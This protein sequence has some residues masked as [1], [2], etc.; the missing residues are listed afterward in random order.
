MDGGFD[1]RFAEYFQPGIQ[2][3][4]FARAQGISQQGTEH[5]FVGPE[6]QWIIRNQFNSLEARPGFDHF[7]DMGKKT[8]VYKKSVG[9]GLFLLPRPQVEQHQHGFGGGRGVVQ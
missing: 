4:N 2:I 5:G 3:G 8:F 7:Q 6:G 1:F 9:A